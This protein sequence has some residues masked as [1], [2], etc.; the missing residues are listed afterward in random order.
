MRYLLLCLLLVPAVAVSGQARTDSVQVLTEIELRDGSRFVGSVTSEDDEVVMLRTLGGSEV[1]ILKSE[2]ASRRRISG[3]VDD[4]ELR[5]FDPHGSRLFFGPTGRSL[6]KSEGYLAA[7]YVFFGFAAYG[8]TD[9]FTMAGGTLLMPQAF[10]DV[11]WV[12]P[13]LG[14]SNSGRTQSSIGVLAGFGDGGGAGVM[15]GAWTRGAPDK[16]FTVGAG[17]GF[18]DGEVDANPV[19][20][21]GLERVTSRRTKLMVESYLVPTLAAGAVVIAG[22]RFFGSGLAADLG[23]VGVVGEDADFPA[24]PWLSF[25]Y[26]FGK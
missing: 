26:H 16:A 6:E 3:R 21:L 1:R 2:I 12:A 23:L 13:R 24:I 11:V 9:R 14:I 22:V 17:L 15:Y 18:A 7:Y 25:A 4:G 5:R 19:V 20:L 8:I 10:G